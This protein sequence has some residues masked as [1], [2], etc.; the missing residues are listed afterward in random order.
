M[1]VRPDN[2]KK[3]TG[4]VLGKNKGIVYHAQTC[5]DMQAVLLILHRPH[6]PLEFS[7]NRITVDADYKYITKAGS[8]GKILYMTRM[9]NIK[10]PVC[11]Y[12]GFIQ[13]D[14]GYCMLHTLRRV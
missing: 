12:N 1:N 13:P 10:A 3:G 7:D 9:D 8:F 6:A 14:T 2:F 4:I 11:G 5:H